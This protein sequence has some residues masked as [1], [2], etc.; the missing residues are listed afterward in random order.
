[1]GATQRR[2]GE[3][4]IKAALICGGRHRLASGQV[5][6]MIFQLELLRFISQRAS[7]PRM[8]NI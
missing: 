8:H 3:T 7:L 2:R 4:V 6:S 5:G 1:M